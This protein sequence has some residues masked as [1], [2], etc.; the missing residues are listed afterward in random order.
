MTRDEMLT[1]VIQKYGFEHD[2]T[3]WF[4]EKVEAETD[5]E[6]LECAFEVAMNDKEDW[7]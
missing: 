4:A 2:K 5:N 3:I 1:A 7:E 6:I